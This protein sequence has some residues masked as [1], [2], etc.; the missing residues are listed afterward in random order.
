SAAKKP[1]AKKAADA[2]PTDRPEATASEPAGDGATPA[3]DGA[4]PAK[5]KR[6]SRVKS[7][8]AVG[9]ESEAS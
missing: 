1:A 9:A 8:A 5:P 7:K 6:V 3:G 4:T 2:A